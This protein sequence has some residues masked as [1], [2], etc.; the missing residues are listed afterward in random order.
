MYKN[1]QNVHKSHVKKSQ[2]VQK[3]PKVNGPNFWHISRKDL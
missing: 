3:S 1:L 2:N